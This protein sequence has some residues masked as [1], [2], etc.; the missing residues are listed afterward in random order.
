MVLVLL[1]FEEIRRFF[2]VGFRNLH[3]QTQFYTAGNKE[4]SF[5]KGAVLDEVVRRKYDI[6]ALGGFQ[7]V[8]KQS[9]G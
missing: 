2:L 9:P 7:D 5:C 4:T 8:V 1:T 6:S 3:E